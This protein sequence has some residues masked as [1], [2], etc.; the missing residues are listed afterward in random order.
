MDDQ[1]STVSNALLG[2]NSQQG[3]FRF[4]ANALEKP[5]NDDS[6]QLAY[7]QLFASWEKEVHKDY[8][9]KV[10][11]LSVTK[12]KVLAEESE[13]AAK[14]SQ[15][16]ESASNEV[17]NEEDLVGQWIDVKTLGIGIVTGFQTYFSTNDNAEI[18]TWRRHQPHQRKHTIDFSHHDEDETAPST[19]I[20]HVLLRRQRNGGLDYL[21][22]SK[23][24]ATK[25][26]EAARAHGE[27]REAFLSRHEGRN[28]QGR[29]RGQRSS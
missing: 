6:R 10:A 3:L 23:G 28:P 18:P 24:D 19:N 21:V 4:A 14:A 7:R 13:T 27:R 12:K 16:C 11:E 5:K 1:S 2:K 20:Q 8:L 9:E 22:C 29:A 17:V 25:A 26:A 15:L